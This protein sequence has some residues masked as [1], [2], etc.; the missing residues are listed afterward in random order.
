MVFNR[1]QRVGETKIKPEYFGDRA[2]TTQS[3][4][5]YDVSGMYLSNLMREQPTGPFVRRRK[6]H[7]FKI[8]KSYAQGER[9]MEWIKWME[10]QLQIKTQHKYNNNEKRLGGRRLPVDAYAKLDDGTEIVLQFYGC[11]YH[12][13]LCAYAPTGLKKNKIEDLAKQL[14]TYEKLRYISK[15]SVMWFIR[16]GSANS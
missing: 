12:C 2:R 13:H 6:E 11:W 5:G 14:D 16:F 7:G 9:A 8:E 4:Q 3:C 1:Y 15:S 10:K